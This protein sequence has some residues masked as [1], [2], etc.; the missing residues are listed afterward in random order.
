M[1]DVPLLDKICANIDYSKRELWGTFE[2][3]SFTIPISVNSKKYSALA[4]EIKKN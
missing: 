1:L 2:E 3:K 4:V